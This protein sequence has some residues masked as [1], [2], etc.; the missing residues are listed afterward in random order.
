MSLVPAGSDDGAEVWEVVIESDSYSKTAI[1]KHL[2]ATNLSAE[3]V[4]VE[5]RKPHRTFRAVDAA[6]L[7]AIVG[8]AGSNLAALIA[9]LLQLRTNHKSRQISIE[10]ASGDK[11][12]VPADISEEALSKLVKSLERKPKRLFLP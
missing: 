3:G 6:I 1:L 12:D 8:A 5:L 7:V 10:L 11:I 9:G 4:A 2:T